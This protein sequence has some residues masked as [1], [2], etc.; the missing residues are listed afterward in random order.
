MFDIVLIV[1]TVERGVFNKRME[2]YKIG[3]LTC[4]RNVFL[5][6]VLRSFFAKSRGA[7]SCVS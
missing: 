3:S 6:R 2:R 7:V 1:N 5:C 4:M